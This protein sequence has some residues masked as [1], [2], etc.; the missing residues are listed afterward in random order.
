MCPLREVG[1]EPG[2]ASTQ[3]EAA[4]LADPL[5]MREVEILRLVA[6]RMTNQKIAEQLLVSMSSI[7]TQINRSWRK[8]E[9]LSRTQVVAK[10][11]QHWIV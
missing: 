6:A 11:R 10:T 7:K 9:L 5:T 8:L 3:A 2:T 1:V 4:D